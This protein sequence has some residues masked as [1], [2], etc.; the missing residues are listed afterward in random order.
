MISVSPLCFRCTYFIFCIIFNFSNVFVICCSR[1]SAIFENHFS[2]NIYFLLFLGIVTTWRTARNGTLFG[3][4]GVAAVVAADPS[5]PLSNTYA[6]PKEDFTMVSCTPSM[7]I[8]V[9]HI[10]SFPRV[11]LGKNLMKS[12]FASLML[13]RLSRGGVRKSVLTHSEM[14]QNWFH[15]FKARNYFLERMLQSRVDARSRVHGRARVD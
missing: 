3:V 11:A 7:Y 9:F 14:R 5:P 6:P 12:F 1:F 8:I 2:N 10:I 15:L 13:S 4:V